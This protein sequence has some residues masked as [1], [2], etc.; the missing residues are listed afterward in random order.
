MKKYMKNKDFIPEKFYDKKQIIENK[1][2]K[3]ILI[4]FLILNLFL[5]PTTLKNIEQTRRDAVINKTNIEEKS[6]SDVEF[7]NIRIWIENILN[8]NVEEA[9]INK[10]KGEITISSL[11]NI[12]VLSG[13]KSITISDVNLENDGQYKLGVSLYE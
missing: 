6:L 4:L 10:N 13:N 12:D 8:D 2:E 9:Y 1:K 3:G 11:E 5:L 7:D